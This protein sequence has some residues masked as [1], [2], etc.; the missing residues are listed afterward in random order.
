MFTLPPRPLLPATWMIS[1]NDQEPSCGSRRKQQCISRRR[2]QINKRATQ[3]CEDRACLKMVARA[4]DHQTRISDPSSPPA[5]P[6]GESENPP[7]LASLFDNSFPSVQPEGGMGERGTV[8]QM[9]GIDT[10]SNFFAKTPEGRPYSHRGSCPFSSSRLDPCGSGG[11]GQGSQFVSSANG[12]TNQLDPRPGARP[13]MSGQRKGCWQMQPLTWRGIAVSIFVLLNVISLSSKSVLGD[14]NPVNITKGSTPTDFLNALLDEHRYDSRL[15]PNFNGDPTNITINFFVASFGSINELSME[16][17]VDMYLRQTWV[18]PRLKHS[19]SKPLVLPP[20]FIDKIWI[21]DLFFSNEKSSYFH[22]VT[23]PN[24]YIRIASDGEVL[25]SVRLTL[26]LACPMVL[27][28]FPLD[29]QVCSVQLESYG[30]STEDVIFQWAPEGPVQIAEDTELPQFS[31]MDT[32]TSICTK[33]YSTGAFTCLQVSFTLQREFGFYLLQT[34]VPSSLIVV[35]SWVSFWIS[36]DAVP[37]RISLGV[38]TVLTVTTQLSASQQS[39]PRVSYTKA[40]DVWM[41]TCM[42]FV[43]AALM[44]FALVNVLSRKRPPQDHKSDPDEIEMMGLKGGKKASKTPGGI[45]NLHQAI[46]RR[47][48]AKLVD[49]FSRIFFPASFFLFNFA[50]WLI[51]NPL[52]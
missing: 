10:S 42:M 3:L 52:K 4:V 23:V 16:Y 7:P 11:R 24:R 26:T 27:K 51:Y 44:E 20:K 9:R 5:P 41:S 37:A 18:D 29:T 28:S 19:Y 50:Y 30:Y 40:I 6:H 43:F 25:Y 47:L 46:N 49:K 31:L 36:S 39:V 8:G 45:R 15:R 35:L 38:T 22:D 13:T 14:S 1:A 32:R 34:Y 2:C 21:A 33:V 12:G 17:T 48:H